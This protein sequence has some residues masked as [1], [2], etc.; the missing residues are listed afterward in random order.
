MGK[1][2]LLLWI[3]RSTD[4]ANQ[5]LPVSLVLTKGGLL[6]FDH[7][8]SVESAWALHETVD[9]RLIEDIDL[10]LTDGFVGLLHHAI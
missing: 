6:Q 8:R 7:K 10:V 1:L 4:E 3:H 5:P 9:P 2:N